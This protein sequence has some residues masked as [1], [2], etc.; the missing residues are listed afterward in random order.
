MKKSELAAQPSPDS[1][2]PPIPVLCDLCRIQGE[3][4]EYPFAHLADL[5]SFT[6]VPRRAHANGWSPEVQRAFIAALVVTGSPRRAARAIGRHAFGAEQLR[7][8]RGGMSFAAA[9]DAALD[10]SRE[11]ELAA[12]REGLTELAAE[13]EEERHARRAAILP[14][15]LREG[16]GEG[17]LELPSRERDR[18]AQSVRGTDEH[19]RLGE[20]LSDSE[21]SN[22][23]DY[24]EAQSR[25]RDRL[26]RARRLLLSMISDDQDKRHAWEVLIGPVDWAKAE[27]LEAQDD[28]PFGE[29]AWSMRGPDMLLT[30]EAGLIPDVVGGPDALKEI[31]Q[32][33]SPSLVREGLGEGMSEDE[34]FCEI[35]DDEAN[36]A[37]RHALRAAREAH[38][39]DFDD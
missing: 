23:Q 26:T 9:W 39:E 24:L 33:L 17:L 25:I 27:R 34:D 19:W 36:R 31:R 2:T 29:R 6:P 10:I 14:S 5:L 18:S 32:R 8:A 7:K 15:R 3:A 30:A 22:H 28:E 11:R 38:P 16:S 37:M 1:A 4:G 12:L 13:N 35:D 20:G 21:E